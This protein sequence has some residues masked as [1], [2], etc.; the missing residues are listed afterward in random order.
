MSNEPRKAKTL[1]V[2]VD[3]LSTRG[4]VELRRGYELDTVDGKPLR[5]GAKPRADPG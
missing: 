3:S 4:D 1:K 2:C 5:S